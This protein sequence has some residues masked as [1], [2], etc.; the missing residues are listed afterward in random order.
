MLTIQQYSIYSTRTLYC[1]DS[2]IYYCRI[3]ET[4]LYLTFRVGIIRDY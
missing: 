2:T 1:S 4:I 3:S